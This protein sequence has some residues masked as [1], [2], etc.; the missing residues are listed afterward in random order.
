MEASGYTS[1]GAKI[2]TTTP[3]LSSDTIG[4]RIRMDVA[5]LTHSGLI[6]LALANSSTNTWAMSSTTTGNTNQ[7]EWSAGKKSLSGE[8][9]QIGLHLAGGETYDAGAINIVYI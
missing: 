5:A 3:S 2:V 6:I 4:F 1:T 8:L 7:I 9:T